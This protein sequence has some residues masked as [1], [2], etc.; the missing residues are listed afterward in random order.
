MPIF[1]IYMNRSIKLIFLK[2]PFKSR[3]LFITM[4]ITKYAWS[5][6][7]TAP[8]SNMILH[9]DPWSNFTIATRI[10]RVSIT[11]FLMPASLK[12][13]ESVTKE[14]LYLFSLLYNLGR[15]GNT[16]HSPYMFSILI[17]DQ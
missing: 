13:N 10:F 3:H 9:L 14:E 6:T 5:S 17:H 15:I 8:K 12:Y 11:K 16:L 2:K 7:L 1:K 4:S